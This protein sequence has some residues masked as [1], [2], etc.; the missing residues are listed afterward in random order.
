MENQL[1]MNAFKEASRYWYMAC[2]YERVNP[3]C[4]TIE[5]SE[6]NPHRGNYRKAL[7]KMEEFITK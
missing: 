3:E 6:N 5:L 1:F 7:E 2:N 4:S